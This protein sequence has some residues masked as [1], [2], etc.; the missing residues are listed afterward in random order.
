GAVA[1]C[2]SSAAAFLFPEKGYMYQECG[3]LLEIFRFWVQQTKPCLKSSALAAGILFAQGY[4]TRISE[5]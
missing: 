3:K 2:K 1:E 5:R 4:A